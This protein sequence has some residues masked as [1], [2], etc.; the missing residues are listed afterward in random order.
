MGGD[1]AP[2]MVVEGL[3]IAAER[4]PGARFLLVGDEAQ[5]APLL[6]APS[7]RRRRL[8]H[9]PRARG[10]RQRHEADRRAAGAR[11]LDARRDRRRGRRRGLR[12]GHRRQHRRAAGAGQ[13]RHQDPARHRPAG[14]GGDRP[15]GAR[16][17]GAARPRRQRAVRRAQPGRIRRDGRRVRAHRARTDRALDRP[18]ERRLRGTEGRRHAA[19]GRRDAARQPYRA[20]VRRASSRATTSPP[21]PPTWWSPTASPATS[22]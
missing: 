14:D 8:R 5:L 18:A 19:A 16:R 12:R 11:L 6:A 10:D 13:D 9:P 3:E 20:A 17:R 4:H 1:H 15:L 22:R 7:P 21:A 2:L